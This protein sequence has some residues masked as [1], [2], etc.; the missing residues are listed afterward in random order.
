MTGLSLFFWPAPNL[1]HLHTNCKGRRG[2]RNHLNNKR[3]SPRHEF[4]KRLQLMRETG[5]DWPDFFRPSFYFSFPWIPNR[6]TKST[7]K[8]NPCCPFSLQNKTKLMSIVW[9]NGSCTADCP[10]VSFSLFPNWKFERGE[11][12]TK[13][14]GENWTGAN[15]GESPTSCAG[16]VYIISGTDF[17]KTHRPRDFVGRQGF[18]VRRP[19][20][21]K[22]IPSGKRRRNCVGPVL[23]PFVVSKCAVD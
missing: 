6:F 10:S 17:N 11:R 20:K 16:L 4:G 8:K 9:R 19:A 5:P 2:C 13:S 18:L 21:K 1:V 23:A 12:K 15:G 14:K 3:P 22:K 7:R